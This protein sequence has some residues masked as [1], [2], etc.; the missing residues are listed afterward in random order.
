MK[1]KHFK[2]ISLLLNQMRP[3]DNGGCG[4]SEY[5]MWESL[6]NGL[7]G[8]LEGFSSPQCR[9]DRI[10]WDE[11]VYGHSANGEGVSK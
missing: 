5:R 10:K 11:A 8:V 2:E 7:A 9:F 4:L 1:S 6:A 3:K